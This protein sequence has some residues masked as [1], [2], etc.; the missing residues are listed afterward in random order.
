VDVFGFDPAG[1]VLSDGLELYMDPVPLAMGAGSQFLLRRQRHLG[2][3]MSLA[4]CY[5]LLRGFP[6]WF[7]LLLVATV[8]DPRSPVVSPSVTILR[9]CVNTQVNRLRR[10]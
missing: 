10:R 2:G 3:A 5:L 6:L 4:H 1:H 9:D 7:R 8:A